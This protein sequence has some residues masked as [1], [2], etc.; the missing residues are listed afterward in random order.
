MKRT[1]CVRG[2][3]I[4]HNDTQQNDIQH[5]NTALQLMKDVTQHDE[6]QQNDIQHK[7]TQHN[8]KWNTLL[9]IMSHNTGLCYAECY[10]DKS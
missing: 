10:H 8:N 9:S 5:N 7:N 2:R 1:E 3:D 4:Q 6:T